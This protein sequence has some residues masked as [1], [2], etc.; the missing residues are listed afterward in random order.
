[1]CQAQIKQ[2]TK[3]EILTFLAFQRNGQ[4][5]SSGQEISPSPRA[6]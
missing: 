4:N 5:I 1:M 6:C 3:K 2:K